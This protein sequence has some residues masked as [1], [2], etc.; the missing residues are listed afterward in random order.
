MYERRTILN[1]FC[2]THDCRHRPNCMLSF[3]VGHESFQKSRSNLHR[4]SLLQLF[5]CIAVPYSYNRCS[6]SMPT[7]ASKA[8]G[9]VV[10][11][12]LKTTAVVGFAL[13][14]SVVLSTVRGSGERGKSRQLRWSSSSQILQ[15]S[16]SDYPVW[17]G[18]LWVI[19]RHQERGI[20]SRYN[21]VVESEWS[22]WWRILSDLTLAGLVMA[23]RPPNNSMSGRDTDDEESSDKPMVD[24]SPKARTVRTT[25]RETD[26]ITKSERFLQQIEANLG[27]TPTTHNRSSTPILNLSAE[28]R[29]SMD[30]SQSLES[31]L[32][33]LPK[34]PSQPPPQSP[35]QRYLE[36]LVHNVS[37]TDLVLSLKAPEDATSQQSQD[38]TFRLCR[39]RFS[40]F[41]L[42]SRRVLDSL[43]SCE[44][45]QLKQLLISFPRYQRSEA[46]NRR[47]F[48]A[49]DAMDN[50]KPLEELPIG[51]SLEGL[52]FQESVKHL[53][54]VSP[55]E[56]N[57]L[58]LRGKDNPRLDAPTEASQL[59]AAFFPLL[60]TLLPQWQ[61]RLEEKYASME[62]NMETNNA[63]GSQACKKVIILVSGVGSPRNWTHSMDG[64]STNECS[65]LMELFIETLYPEVAVVR[66]HSSTNIFRYDENIAFIQNE[67]LPCVE[68]YRD[69]H[70]TGLPY[71]DELEH[72]RTQ[73]DAIVRVDH[74]SFDPDWNQSMS[75]TLS[76]ADGS[77]ARNHAIQ[78][79]LRSYRPTYFH[80]WQLKTFWHEMKIV[81]SDIEVHAFEEMETLPPI[82]LT[83]ALS[84][85]QF[86]QEQPIALQ[87]VEEMKAFKRETES[88]LQLA[89]DDHDLRTFWMRKTKKPV[90]AVL[91]VQMEKN[92]PVKLY[93]GTNM[94]VSMPTG[95]LCAERN[96]IGTALAANPTLKRHHLKI[97]AVLSVSASKSDSGSRSRESSSTSLVSYAQSA[98]GSRRGSMDEQE[99][100]TTSPGRPPR[101]TKHNNSGDWIFHDIS[102]PEFPDKVVH[103]V[104]ITESEKLPFAPNNMPAKRISLYQHNSSRGP[105]TRHD[106]QCSFSKRKSVVVHQSPEDLNPLRPCGACNEWLKKISQASPYFK[107]LTFTDADCSGVYC[108]PVAE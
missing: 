36:L 50:Q 54:E 64:N 2:Q 52:S 17:M 83:T 32:E 74:T 13:V 5:R 20:T 31:A 27:L 92:G 14:G 1:L 44:G 100:H 56:R 82:D 19:A 42:Y 24:Q 89:D 75:V 61:A 37:H 69:A 101:P 63:G 106:R 35:H 9:S 67:L 41:E 18:A 3:E 96:V 55:D 30:A 85:Q 65:K 73:K 15:D 47:I 33:R 28:R 107:I 76:F 43:L 103:D 49:D 84:K 6:A 60:A 86:N 46:E 39:P 62:R 10:S 99:T 29:L 22:T 51:F 45:D 40:A 66:I 102:A 34:L 21:Q 108:C 7:T 93:R 87:V 48:D 78:A 12:I 81:D 68:G 80:C 23:L 105:L 77:P 11:E 94:E 88:I 70:A 95:S 72:I 4:K 26:Q 104:A 98:N 58:R 79:A 91:A 59:N 8:S 38:S 90:L 71:P 53:L 25:V 97:I 57:D 16:L